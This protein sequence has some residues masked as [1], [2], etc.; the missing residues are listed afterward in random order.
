VVPGRQGQKTTFTVRTLADALP[1][2]S[3]PYTEIDRIS[4]EHRRP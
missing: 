2:T 4:F 3:S 1:G